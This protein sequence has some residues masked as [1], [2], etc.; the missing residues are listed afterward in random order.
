[1]IY[2]R[3]ETCAS[4]YIKYFFD[5]VASTLLSRK[6]WIFDFV[7]CVLLSALKYSIRFPIWFWFEYA[8]TIWLRNEIFLMTELKNKSC[9]L[10]CSSCFREKIIENYKFVKVS[11]MDVYFSLL[12]FEQKGLVRKKTAHSYIFLFTS[13]FVNDNKKLL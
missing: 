4:L 2:I 3:E 6:Y 10:F 11:E 9:L 1:M 12:I 8:I 7:F 5:C 13:K